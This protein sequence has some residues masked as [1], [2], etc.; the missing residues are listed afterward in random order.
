MEKGT[1]EK[2]SSFE[3]TYREVADANVKARAVT[4]RTTEEA[5]AARRR[6]DGREEHPGAE[7][8]KVDGVKAEWFHGIDTQGEVVA[9][10]A[11][12]EATVMIR[13]SL[14]VIKEVFGLDITGDIEELELRE[15]SEGV[16]EQFAEILAVLKSMTGVLEEAVEEG[17]AL[18]LDDRCIE[19]AQMVVLEKRLR[20]ETFRLQVSFEKLDIASEVNTRC[21]GKLARPA[22][23]TGIPLAVDPS[24]VSADGAVVRMF[25]ELVAVKTEEVRAV[26]A[27]MA[28]LAAQKQ[29]SSNV[30]QPAVS[31][32][33]TVTGRVVEGGTTVLSAETRPAGAEIGSLDPQVVRKL[34]KIEGDVEVVEGGKGVEGD[35]KSDGLIKGMGIGLNA[36]A[37]QLHQ[38]M[39][40]VNQGVDSVAGPEGGRASQTLF[41]P[42]AL[43]REM[44]TPF[45]SMEE[46]VVNQLA[47]RLN[48]AVRSGTSEVRLTLRP[49]SLGQV[50]LKIQ[51]DGDIVMAK[52]NVENQQVRQ[53]IESNLQALRNAL[54]E[55][56]LQAG[57]F[58][59]DVG[60]QWADRSG[61]E[62]GS[63][64]GGGGP[65]SAGDDSDGEVEHGTMGVTGRETGRRYGTNTIEYF[66]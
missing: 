15:P 34:L 9:S 55:H 21:A 13:Q 51:M 31:P 39:D 40:V 12:G 50:Q 23:G 37:Q 18:E 43:P 63:G 47:E 60:R 56:N 26:V 17:V 16:V 57:D 2:S 52:I 38:V 53:I 6:Y 28:A 58:D 33:T 14:T 61:Q 10:D 8:G 62:E 48:T 49:E 32:A 19:P 3:K 25:E 42:E 4:E 45:R 11:V 65:L 35:T 1:R 29:H 22:A 24:G 64:H 66:A 7:S 20:V 44:G 41:A 59:V 27:K 36:R 5:E 30:K 46:S 54:Q